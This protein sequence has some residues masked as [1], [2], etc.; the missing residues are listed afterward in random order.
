MLPRS[1]RERGRGGYDIPGAVLGTTSMLLLVFT[2][3]EAPEVGWGSART[4]L[5]FAAVAVMLA[6]F[7]AVERRS[8]AR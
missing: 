8:P 7:V 1:E 3:V 6:A 2:V 4:V 5:S